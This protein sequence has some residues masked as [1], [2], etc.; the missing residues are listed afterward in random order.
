MNGILN[1]TMAL[2]AARNAG[3]PEFLQAV[4]EVRAYLSEVRSSG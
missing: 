1:E 2:V 4:R 3:E